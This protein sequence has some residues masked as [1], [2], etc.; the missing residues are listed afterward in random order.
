MRRSS[1]AF[2]QRALLVAILSAG[3][4]ACSAERFDGRT[5]KH[6][7]TSF[8][9][10]PIPS[11]WSRIDLDGP[12]VAFRDDHR[13]TVEVFARCGQDGDDV[14][15]GALT[16][17]LLIGFTEREIDK[18]E[19]TPLDGREAMHTVASA[20]LDGVK[21]SLDIWVMKKDGCVWDLVFVASPSTFSAGVPAFSSFVSAFRT[22][23]E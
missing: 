15:L 4:G 21:V 22:G 9:S 19:L 8:R 16:Q 1:T 12:L 11:S 14:P 23:S 7:R 6:G 10:G 5:Y 13:G 17:H 2:A 20:K 18:Q 3:L